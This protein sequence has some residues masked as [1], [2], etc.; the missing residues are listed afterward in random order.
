MMALPLHARQVCDLPSEPPSSIRGLR[1]QK[2][3]ATFSVSHRLT[4]HQSG[5]ALARAND[6]LLATVINLRF[7][8]TSSTESQSNPQQKV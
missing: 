5:K 4:G 8:V 7:T 6:L 3:N 2:Q 1:P